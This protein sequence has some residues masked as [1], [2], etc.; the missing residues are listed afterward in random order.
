M[1]Q[2]SVSDW[3]T[4]VGTIASLLLAV[5]IFIMQ[6]RQDARMDEFE[7]LT[8]E[9]DEARHQEEVR[10]RTAAFISKYYPDRGLIP[11]CC[12]AAMYNDS[13]FYQREM[14]NEFCSYPREL[15]NS[16]IERCDWRLRVEDSPGFYSDCLAALGE[17]L[18][19]SFS[20]DEALFY[21]FDQYMERSV[22]Y[23][24]GKRE[25][26]R[27]REA[28][29]FVAKVLSEALRGNSERVKPLQTVFDQCDLGSCPENL[30]CW[31]VAV[32]A[33]YISVYSDDDSREEYGS[34]GAWAGET[35]ETL[36]DQF[37]LS[38]FSIYVHLVLPAKNR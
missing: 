3:I 11:L 6:R 23:Y 12:I 8:A 35:I 15:Q 10:A 13:R 18:H 31:T 1:P 30:C 33:Q 2:L 16:I 37:L 20:E 9:K 26:E 29:R 24:P 38:L 32:E 28:Q 17:T 5:I 19:L 34:P 27:I 14:Y 36:E 4:L 25:S 22:I 21:M 7:K